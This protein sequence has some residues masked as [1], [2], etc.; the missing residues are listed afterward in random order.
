MNFFEKIGKTASQTYK[1]TAGKTSKIAKEAKLRI[2]ISDD[3]DKIEDLY[4]EIGEKI[5][6]MYEKQEQIEM[7]MQLKD[8]FTKIDAL[9]EEIKD[10]KTELL[11]LKDSKVCTNCGNT[12]DI[13]SH[14][15]NN[16]GY[17]QETN[18]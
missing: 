7:N 11:R 17:E 18:T 13:E 9:N 14:Y 8:L 12:I 4:I 6:K 15:C 5:Y 1:A 2:L 16:C 10:T 3:E